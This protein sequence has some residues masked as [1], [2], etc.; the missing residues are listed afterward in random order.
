MYDYNDGYGSCL[1]FLI[2]LAIFML[3]FGV[4]GI[5]QTRDVS[6]FLGSLWRFVASIP[7]GVWG[8]SLIVLAVI[9]AT[10]AIVAN[11]RSGGRF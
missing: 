6:T 8:L 9:A 4:F 11:I 2:I 7:P 3:A 10:I 1:L 5:T